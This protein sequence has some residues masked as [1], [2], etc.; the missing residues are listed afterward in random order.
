[1][2]VYPIIFDINPKSGLSTEET[3]V[4]IKGQN[5]NQKEKDKKW[6]GKYILKNIFILLSKKTSG[7]KIWNKNC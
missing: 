3:I 6:N 4:Y 2:K 7:S 5:F 1:M